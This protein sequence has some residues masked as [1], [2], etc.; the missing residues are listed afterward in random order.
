MITEYE[1]APLVARKRYRPPMGESFVPKR[2]REF[3]VRV[4]SAR[5]E[6]LRNKYRNAS[7]DAEPMLLNAHFEVQ[8]C[9]SSMMRGFFK[10]T[11]EFWRTFRSWK[12]SDVFDKE[13]SDF[14][15]IN[16][17]DV[18]LAKLR[19][20]D[21]E[22]IRIKALWEERLG[23]RSTYLHLTRVQRLEMVP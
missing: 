1:W 23:R 6:V 12:Y 10:H 5:L 3:D 2:M 15:D 16:T 9:D 8:V 14:V 13:S 4:V 17:T 22:G 19:V 18:T 20:R 21:G 11:L 7:A